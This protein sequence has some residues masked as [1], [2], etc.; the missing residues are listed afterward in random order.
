MKVYLVWDSRYY[1]YINPVVVFQKESDA[2]EY[3]KEHSY[4]NYREIE[5]K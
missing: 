2:K 3:C 4:S 5:L 1:H